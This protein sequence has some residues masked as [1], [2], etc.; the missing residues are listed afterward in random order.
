MTRRMTLIFRSFDS[1]MA[2][3]AVPWTLQT[4]TTRKKKEEKKVCDENASSRTLGQL[5]WLSTRPERAIGLQTLPMD[6]WM[7]CD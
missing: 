5:P 1:Q 2:S 3:A 4:D 6:G 7:K